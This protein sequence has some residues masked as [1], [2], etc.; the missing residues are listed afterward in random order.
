VKNSFFHPKIR[1]KLFSKLYNPQFPKTFSK[2][3]RA[4]EKCVGKTNMGLED[5]MGLRATI[6]IWA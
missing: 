4:H 1:E 2:K 3:N 6:S 5:K